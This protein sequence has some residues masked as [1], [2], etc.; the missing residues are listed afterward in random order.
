[1]SAAII[2]TCRFDKLMWKYKNS[3]SYRVALLDAGHLSQAVQMVATSIGI[4]TWPTAAFYDHDVSD[5]LEL[6][7]QNMEYPL[8]VIG[9]GSGDP[10]PF[11]RDLGDG[12]ASSDPPAL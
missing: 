5:L 4:R 7:P 3:R 10:N 12:F 9:L 11:D 2:I 8:M 1:M 6:R